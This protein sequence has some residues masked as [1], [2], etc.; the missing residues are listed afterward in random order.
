MWEHALAPLDVCAVHD[1]AASASRLSRRGALQ[2][3]VWRAVDSVL[4]ESPV[5]AHSRGVLT[6][7]VMAA[8]G[9]GKGGRKCGLR[10]VC[11]VAGTRYSAVRIQQALGAGSL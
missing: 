8:G 5:E 10:G 7:S 1:R 4:R 9:V 6:G 11:H 2:G 3:E